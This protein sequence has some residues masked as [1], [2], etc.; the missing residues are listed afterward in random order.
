ML[1][2]IRRFAK[3]AIFTKKLSLDDFAMQV[4]KNKCTIVVITPKRTITKQREVRHTLYFQGVDQSRAVLTEIYE[5]CFTTVHT[6]EGVRRERVEILLMALRRGDALTKSI[7]DL[8]IEVVDLDGKVMN[9]PSRANI[10][11]QADGRLNVSI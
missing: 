7:P 11:A 6:Y 1:D 5:H 4:I 8:L 2:L 3:R 9:P 10:R